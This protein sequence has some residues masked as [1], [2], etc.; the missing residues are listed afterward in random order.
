METGGA[1]MVSTMAATDFSEM[2]EFREFEHSAWQSAVERYHCSFGRLTT[3]IAPALL[4]AAGVTAG[5]AM[6]DIASGPGYVAALGA[7]RGA[8][9]TGM[10]FSP[11][12]VAKA[13]ALYPDLVFVD[14]DAE[15]LP[16]PNAS[17]DAAVMS[18]GLLHLGRPELAVAEAYRVLRPG[19][20]FAFSVWAE[21][22]KAIGFRITLQAIQDHGDPTVQLPPAPP[23]F[24]FSDP[25][26]AKRILSQAG[27]TDITAR[28]QAMLWKLSSPE[29]LFE[30]FH[31]GTARTGGLLR[32]Q[33]AAD[34][35]TIKRRIDDEVRAFVVDGGAEIPMAAW[36][37]AGRKPI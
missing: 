21:R 17:F 31:R 15:A 7:S 26:E 10:D 12:M 30:A 35:R 6:L 1:V 24:R 29:E 36:I 33:S 20:R 18:F 16:F 8:Q 3:Q 34:L 25:T 22:E 4:D 2:E 27:F 14:G 13:H 32:A 19:G 5:T 11:A 37:V 28:E 9:V 23:F